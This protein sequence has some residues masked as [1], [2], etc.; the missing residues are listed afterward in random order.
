MKK[1]LFIVLLLVVAG[2]FLKVEA[3]DIIMGF[4]IYGG[5]Y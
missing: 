2:S 5:R 4:P 3:Q 1:Q